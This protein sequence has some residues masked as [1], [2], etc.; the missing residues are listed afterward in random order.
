MQI[1]LQPV[2]CTANRSGSVAHGGIGR[3]RCVSHSQ[4]WDM[5]DEH[6]RYVK[7]RDRLEQKLKLHR[8]RNPRSSAVVRSFIRI[9]S[10]QP[11]NK[12]KVSGDGSD[13]TRVSDFPS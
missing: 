6:E 9:Q 1:C 11:P 2:Q 12:S 7:A 5:A 13:K 4:V 8:R 3:T 10:V